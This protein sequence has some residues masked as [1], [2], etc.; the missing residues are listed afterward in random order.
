MVRRAVSFAATWM[1][2][3][4]ASASAQADHERL[5]A[6]A[7]DGAVLA[8]IDGGASSASVGGALDLV[9]RRSDAHVRLTHNH[10]RSTGLSAADL[11]QLTKPGVDAIEAVGLD[12][13]R[14]E[15]GRGSRFDCVGFE[16]HQYRLAAAAVSRQLLDAAKS[17]ADRAT[18]DAHHAHLT[19]LAL[20]KAGIIVYS[21][22]L[23]AERA[24]SYER[25]RA[26]F[27]RATEAAAVRLRQ[28][29]AVAR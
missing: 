28:A 14:Y 2:A 26:A 15:A 9:L 21:T 24:S 4:A 3:A 25:Y 13:S 20:H 10:P 27:G 29:D 23:S 22:V 18:I 8:V 19:A 16:P 5:I 6:F 11:E 12:G 7:P 17:P 1:L